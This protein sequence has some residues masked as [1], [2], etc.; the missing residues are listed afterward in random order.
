VVTGDL[1][2]VTGDPVQLRAV[3]QNLVANAAKFT[4]RGE[5]PHIEV[6]GTRIGD[7]WRIEVCDRGPG[8]PEDQQERVFQPPGSTTTSRA[9]ASA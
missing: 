2:T 3:L 7:M 6:D 8:I 9:R 4:R 5:P 1:P